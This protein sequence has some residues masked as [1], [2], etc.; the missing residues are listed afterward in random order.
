M[1]P[2]FRYLVA[3]ARKTGAKIIVRHNLTA[4]FEANQT[5]LPEFFRR[6]SSRRF[7]PA[8]FFCRK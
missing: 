5:D 7:Q 3:E 6:E 4:M 2:D 8:A 1:I